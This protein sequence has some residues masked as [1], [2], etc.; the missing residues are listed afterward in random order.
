MLIDHLKFKTIK[1]PKCGQEY[2]PAEIFYPNT[3]LGEPKDVV[4]TPD[5]KIDFFEGTTMNLEETYCCD[6]CEAPLKIKANVSFECVVEKE[7]DF[8]ED[9][10]SVIYS[11]R[12]KLKEQDL[13]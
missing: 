1:C 2:L 9:Y 10:S 3:F 8:T 11:D 4:R 7:K 13:F 6:N 12:I 5:G